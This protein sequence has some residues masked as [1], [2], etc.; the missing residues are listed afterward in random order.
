MPAAIAARP[1]LP[2]CGHE[3]VNRQPTGDYYDAA[4]W[5]C[6]IE[7][8]D[9]GAQAEL[10]RDS[11]TPEAGRIRDIYRVLAD[12]TIEWFID[13]SQDPLSGREWTRQTC[14]DLAS[15]GSDPN[16]TPIYLPRDCDVAEVV[17]TGDALDAPT[18]DEIAML[19]RLV[20]FARSPE[21]QSLDGIPLSSDGVALGLAEHL[22]VV[23]T[24]DELDDPGAWVLAAE[25][26]RG[27]VGPFSVLDVLG[28]WQ[29]FA[30][31][32]SVGEASVSVGS[33][34]HC[35]SPPVEAPP[36]VAGFRRVSIQPAG[37]DSCLPWW[38]VDL[39][40]DAEGAIE[41]ITLDLWEP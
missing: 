11:L 10:I 29:R 5:A 19:E 31:G 30:D 35:A 6:F 25:A 8:R 16:G 34:P 18:G 20:L 21:T 41:A 17:I 22:I 33:H 27:H 1:A 2:S 3:T 39:Y 32:P 23:R 7:A 12:G 24:P 15:V 36:G 9:A 28:E 37:I 13:A 38:T 40:L 26:F 14:A 4:A